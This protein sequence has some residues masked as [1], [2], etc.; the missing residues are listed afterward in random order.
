M[1]LVPAATP[2]AKPLEL[3]VA[4]L[5]V[6]DAHVAVLDR[7][8]VLPSL[9]VP[10]AVNCWLSPFNIA[11]LVGVTAIDFRIFHSVMSN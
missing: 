3:T 6:P 1:L 11:G 2:V 8:C 10:I 7:F 5:V 9:Y 4:T